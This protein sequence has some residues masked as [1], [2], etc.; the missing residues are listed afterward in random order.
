MLLTNLPF[1]QPGQVAYHCG[2]HAHYALRVP[3][4]GVA[5]R[6][7]PRAVV[8]GAQA[9]QVRPCRPDRRGVPGHRGEDRLRARHLEGWERADRHCYLTIPPDLLVQVP[10]RCN[11]WT[12]PVFALRAYIPE[13]SDIR[14]QCNHHLRYAIYPASPCPDFVTRQSL[15]H[16]ETS[17]RHYH[18]HTKLQCLPGR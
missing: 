5:L 10:L 14:T 3:V 4:G 17:S 18:D 7:G 6:R 16:I 2:P 1:W 12:M 11:I 15:V 8:C 13:H 9:D